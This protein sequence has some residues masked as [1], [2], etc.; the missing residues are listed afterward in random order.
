MN[1]EKT[2]NEVVISQMP[3]NKRDVEDIEELCAVVQVAV[4]PTAVSRL[5]NDT[6]KHPRPVKISFPTPFDART[7]LAKADAARKEGNDAT[8]KLRCRPCRTQEE[9]SKFKKLREEVRNLNDGAVDGQSFSLRNN[10]EVWKFAQDAEGKW[11]RVQG[12]THTS[13]VQ[14]LRP[15]SPAMPER[16]GNQA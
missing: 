5:G 11:R 6:T 3:E 4:R 13:S 15:S 10:G 16:S 7:F 14:R 8:K 9:Q 2:R 12:W 1:D